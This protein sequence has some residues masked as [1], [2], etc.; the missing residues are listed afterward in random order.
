M[1]NIDNV[2][3]HYHNIINKLEDEKQELL[4]DKARLDFLLNRGYA[5]QLTKGDIL[6][7]REKIDE[8]IDI[9]NQFKKALNE[10]TL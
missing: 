10:V 6:S 8:A 4:K 1:N 9:A 5:V 7:S 2:E 3:L